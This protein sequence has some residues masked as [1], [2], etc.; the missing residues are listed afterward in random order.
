MTTSLPPPP[1]VSPTSAPGA[2]EIGTFLPG[3]LEFERELDNEAE[4]LEIQKVAKATRENQ[5]RNLGPLQE[6]VL[7]SADHVRSLW[8]CA[9]ISHIN[10]QMENVFHTLA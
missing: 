7:R 5:L 8:A 3:M 1:K 2:H 4:D 6:R 9:D 10:L